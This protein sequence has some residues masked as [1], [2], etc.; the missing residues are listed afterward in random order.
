MR[1]TYVAWFICTHRGWLGGARASIR[2]RRLTD[3]PPT[4]YITQKDTYEILLGDMNALEWVP[5]SGRLD[6]R[7]L[8]RR[9]VDG[10]HDTDG[11]P[12][13]VV[14]AMHKGIYQ[15]GKAGEKLKA[16]FIPFGGDEEEI[17]VSLLS[18][19]AALFES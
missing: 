12:L 10:G 7:A 2:T 16:A 8:G 6:V 15:P 9:P 14:R 19:V 17:E 3:R 4:S 1:F 11:S 13:Y 5:T 18:V